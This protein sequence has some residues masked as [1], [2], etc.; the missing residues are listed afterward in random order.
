MDLKYKIG[1]VLEDKFN[2]L[3]VVVF[4]DE[5]TKLYNIQK[6]DVQQVSEVKLDNDFILI[7]ELD[8]GE[9]NGN[10]SCEN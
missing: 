7:D 1:D 3:W 8:E 5:E 10:Q 6:I 9:L 4:Y 2:N